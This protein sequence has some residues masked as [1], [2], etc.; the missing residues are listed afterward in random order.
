MALSSICLDFKNLLLGHLKIPIFTD[1]SSL[2]L[3]LITWFF[4]FWH[5]G[6]NVWGVFPFS[7]TVY[8]PLLAKPYLSCYWYFNLF[9]PLIYIYNFIRFSYQKKN[10]KRLFIFFHSIYFAFCFVVITNMKPVSLRQHCFYWQKY[11]RCWFTRV[12]L[13]EAR[14][15]LSKIRL[16]FSLNP[17]QSFLFIRH[18][19]S[20]VMRGI[21]LR[22]ICRWKDHYILSI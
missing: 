22:Q 19:N 7:L 18:S 1:S 4:K 3:S 21:K 11:N 5:Q 2:L 8:I 14:W 9:S 16:I 12:S 20:T 17:H 6:F 10:Q 15:D 13:V